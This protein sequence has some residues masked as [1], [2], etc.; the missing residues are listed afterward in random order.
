MTNLTDLVFLTNYYETFMIIK[1]KIAITR[2]I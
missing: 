1:E 2:R